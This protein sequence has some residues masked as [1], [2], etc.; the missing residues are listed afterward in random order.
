MRRHIPSTMALI[1]F[2]AAARCENFTQAATEINLTQS[3][4]SRQIN[5][6][7]EMVGQKLF[8]RSR[9]RVKL[10]NAGL[11]YLSQIQPLLESIEVATLRMPSFEDVSG[12][13]NIGTYPTLGSRWLMAHL[14]GFTK[15]NPEINTNIVT[16]LDNSYFDPD[17]IDIGIVQGDPPWADCQQDFLFSEELAAI[18]SPKLL[19]KA[20]SNPLHL[21]DHRLLVH[22]TR[23]ISWDIWFDSVGVSKPET[24][25]ILVFPQF[26]MIIEAT[27]EGHGIAMLPLLLIERELASGRLILAHDH[28]AKPESGYYLISPNHKA[29][30][31]KVDAF[32]NWMLSHV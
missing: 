18:A 23:P 11:F 13:L 30:T 14:L 9:Q 3:A 15:E 20:V 4:L 5:L 32:R 6:L 12:A 19:D 31:P 10:S 22:N 26:D 8:L 2:E 21:I 25:S 7:E 1:C 28:I 17:N 27:L 24:Q 16:Y 29:K